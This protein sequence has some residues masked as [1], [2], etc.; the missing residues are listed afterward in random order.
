[1]S[2]KL[3]WSMT[4]IPPG[5]M[6]SRKLDSATFWLCSEPSKS[7]RCENELP[8]Q[9]TASNPPWG[10]PSTSLRSSERD[11]QFASSITETPHLF[12]YI[13]MYARTHECTHIHTYVLNHRPTSGPGQHSKRVHAVVT[14]CSDN[15]SPDLF[16]YKPANT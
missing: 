9:I 6:M 8:K 13:H 2:S 12:F 11:N 7:G 1:M 16:K 15:A 3:R 10:T 14:Q 4:R 5:L